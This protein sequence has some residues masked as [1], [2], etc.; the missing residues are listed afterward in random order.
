[1]VLTPT[2]G[3]TPLAKTSTAASVIG[4]PICVFC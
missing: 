4:F 2:G 3:L 1:V